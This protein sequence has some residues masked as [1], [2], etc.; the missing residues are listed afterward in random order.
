MYCAECAFSLPSGAKFCPRC[1]TRNVLAEASPGSASEGA[2]LQD[3]EARPA[4]ETRA[5]ADGNA[6]VASDEPGTP[7]R[8]VWEALEPESPPPPPAP[9]ESLGAEEPKPRLRYA[10]AGSI[11]L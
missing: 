7:H 4:S 5:D 6:S 8:F 11:T 2:S 3:E 1:S 10:N 9:L